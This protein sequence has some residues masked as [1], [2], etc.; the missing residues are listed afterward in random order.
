LCIQLADIGDLVVTTPALYGLRQTFPDAQIDVL[1]TPH[2]APILAHTNLVDQVWTAPRQIVRLRQWRA[3]LPAAVRV[4]AALRR[5]RYDA[6][7]LFHHLTTWIGVGKYALL[8]W[9]T[10]ARLRA[11]LDNGRGGFLTHRTRDAGWGV[12]H[13]A[14]YYLAVAGLVGAKSDDQ[15]LRV[16]VSEADHAWAESRL[17]AGARYYAIHAGSGGF[18][19][20]RRWEPEKFAAVVNGWADHDVSRGA[21]PVRVVLVGGQGDDAEAVLPHLRHPSINLVNQTTL[22]QVAAVLERCA[23]FIGADSG[24]MHIAAAV[25]GGAAQRSHGSNGALRL[26]VVFG[27]SHHAAWSP[28]LPAAPGASH[29]YRSGVRCSPCSYVGHTLGLRHGCEARTCMKLLTAAE[30]GRPIPAPTPAGGVMDGGRRAALRVLGVPIHALTFAAFLD[31]IAAW[32]AEGQPRQVCTVNPEYIMLAQRDVLLYLILSRADLCVADGVG[33]LWAARR[34]GRALPERVTGS[35]GV[36]KIAERAAR[37]GW[38]LFLLGA[39]PGVAARTA[40]MLQ[41]RYPGLQIAGVHAGTPSAQDEDEIATLIA[42]SRADVLFVAFGQ[43]KQDHWIAR[44]LPRLNVN[45]AIG[46]GG[47]FDFIAGVRQRA[48]I[49]MQQAGLEWLFRLIQQPSRWRRMLRLP[50]FVIEVLRR[51]QRGPWAFDP[52]PEEARAPDGRW[53]PRHD[54]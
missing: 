6:V 44:N 49:W 2:A 34:L 54:G 30:V 9:A 8:A 15:R 24:V 11:G 53:E 19:L 13:Q 28:Y 3:D 29:L 43:G 18:S 50:Q 4:M 27:P 1:T 37:D 38:R 26:H 48:P 46:V 33:V 41:D 21:E 14:A 31:Q 16:G 20:A 39:A 5:G 36:L 17:P 23:A 12:Q 42:A 7:L 52:A 22:N 45:V 10:G 35:D 51:G 25:A 32:I 40:Q 47:S